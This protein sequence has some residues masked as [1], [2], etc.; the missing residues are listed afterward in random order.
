MDQE[1][2]YPMTGYPYVRLPLL[3]CVLLSAPAVFGAAN[4]EDEL[5][6]FRALLDAQQTQLAAL[7]RTV[8]QQ[9][10]LLDAQQVLLESLGAAPGGAAVAGPGGSQPVGP[11]GSQ[12]AGSVSTPGT[13]EEP[14]ASASR[15][16]TGRPVEDTPEDPNA[17]GQPSFFPGAWSVPGS[18]AAMRIGGYVKLNFVNNFDPLVIQ[19]RFI[20]GAIPPDGF[21]LDGATE[22]FAVTAQQSRVNL[23]LREQTSKGSLR[24]F[25]EGDF[26]GS[27]DTF[28]LR[29]AFGQFG[30]LLAGKTWSTLMDLDASPEEL[31]FEGINGRINVRQAQL[32]FFPRVGKALNLSVSLEDPAPDISGGTGISKWPDIV[33]G[34]DRVPGGR[35]AWADRKS[36]WSARTNVIGRQIKARADDVG[37]EKSAI[38]WGIVASGRIP[39]RVWD[40]RDQFLWQ[41]IYGDGIGRYV[42][43]LGTLGGQDAIFSP[44]GKLE[45]LPVFAGYLSYQHWWNARWRSNATISWVKVDGYDYQSSEDYQ[46]LFGP[47][48]DRTLRTAIN[49]LFTP[50][51]RVE[52][53]AELLWGER[54]NGDGSKGD[55][56]QLQVSAKYLY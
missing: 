52:L 6:G 54:E 21:S 50:V 11:G 19:D 47:A 49:L 30:Q 42:N 12:P 37:T 44:E 16:G 27:G 23:D 53:G 35:L 25:V 8:E 55:A 13:A 26:A 17:A 43:D 15:H 39:V 48:Y 34:V 29:H 36:G 56:S 1:A 10:T 32:R 31:D 18:N 9:Q 41:M 5:A 20:V 14:L 24:A 46:A 38:G 33:I 7:Q 3:A 40:E 4:L 22:G 28:R 2:Q 51:Q 45:T